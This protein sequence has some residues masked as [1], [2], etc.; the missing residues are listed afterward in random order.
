MSIKIQTCY[1]DVLLK[2]HFQRLLSVYNISILYNILDYDNI[3][4]C[5]NSPKLV[6]IALNL[7]RKLLIKNVCIYYM[8]VYNTEMQHY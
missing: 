3:L 1:A 5:E 4:L 8:F 2:S 6:T 7:I